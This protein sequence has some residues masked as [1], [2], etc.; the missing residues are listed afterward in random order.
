MASPSSLNSFLLKAK[1]PEAANSGENWTP[2][3]K[4]RSTPKVGRSAQ[5]AERFATMVWDFKDRLCNNRRNVAEIR[6][7]PSHEAETE[8]R[9]KRQVRHI[10]QF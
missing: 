4:A 10:D 3:R 5:V 8:P 6:G 9:S 2:Q 1:D 7:M